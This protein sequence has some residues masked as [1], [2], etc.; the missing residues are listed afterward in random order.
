[1]NLNYIDM[2]T[3]DILD[4]AKSLFVK[5]GLA[6]FTEARCLANGK[7]VPPT[8]ALADEFCA[9]GAVRKALDMYGEPCGLSDYTKPGTVAA[10][11]YE[12]LHAV[13]PDGMKVVVFNDAEDT[14]KKQITGLFDSA[15]LW[16]LS[17]GLAK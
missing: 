4:Y 2:R 13:L 8:S 12:A 1:M 7:D 11:A 14:T 6:K 17:G 16:L 3:R 10:R 9:L 5:H 15:S